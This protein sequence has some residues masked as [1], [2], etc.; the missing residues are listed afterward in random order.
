MYGERRGAYRVQVGKPEG[1]R[2]LGDPHVDGRILK[3]IFRNWEGAGCMYWID[4]A[5]DSH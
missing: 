2:S 3:W 1:K 4:R 5:Q